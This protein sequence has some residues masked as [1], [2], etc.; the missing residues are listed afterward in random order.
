MNELLL[1]YFAALE[2][3]DYQAMI[4]LFED[5]AKVHSPLYGQ[6]AALVF[7]RD[8]FADTVASKI[9]PLNVLISQSNPQVGAAHF[10]YDWTMKNGEVTHFECVDVIALGASGKIKELKIIYD[11]FGTTREAFQTL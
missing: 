8:L 9:T 3:G 10:R 11:T 6:M 1:R 2:S 7:Y 5:G 4:A